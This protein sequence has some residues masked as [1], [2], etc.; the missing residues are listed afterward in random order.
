MAGMVFVNH[1]CESFKWESQ[2]SK[3][4]GS[5]IVSFKQILEQGWNVNEKL[6]GKLKQTNFQRQ[7][8]K[9]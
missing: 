4:R 3:I 2:G 6:A 1:V 7:G 8:V 5:I 9:L